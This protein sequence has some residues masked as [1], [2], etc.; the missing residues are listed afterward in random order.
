MTDT[1]KTDVLVIGA[2][3]AGIGVAA[4]LASTHRVTVIEREDQPG[5][6]STGRSA[7][8][9]LPNY[10]N[11]VIRGLNKVSAPLFE[12]RDTSLFPQPL[13]TPRGC[14][15]VADAASIADL[16]NFARTSVG[17]EIISVD[18]AVEMV[19]ILNA[20]HIAAACYQADAWDI[21]VNAL[22]QGWLRKA[23]SLG[24]EIHTRS[25]VTGAERIGDEWH[26]QAGGKT[27]VAQTIVNASGAWADLTA[28]LFGARPLGLTPLRRSIAVLPAPE[29]HDTRGW[30]LVDDVNEAWYMKPDGGRM[31][32][33][34]CD[35]TP[36]D[37]HDAFAD[38][39]V[40]AEGLY[41][42]EQAVTVPVTRVEHSWAGLRTFAPDRT[43]VAGFDADVEGFFWLA[44]QGGY[45][46]QTSPALSAL[47]AALIRGDA[48][49]AELE[50]LLPKLSPARFS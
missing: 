18:R 40:L 15:T 3:I 17:V 38:D 6:H 30:P 46:I 21:D 16:E 43:P 11:D 13:L 49:E 48:P 4:A 44:G 9:F 28:A 22:H 31:F 14:L 29:N 37:P 5:Y 26:V 45:G 19:P 27:F 8:I 7:A 12:N 2:G 36:V 20:D 35:E 33:S 24:V 41:R 39:M 47:A 34:P 25:E 1:I 32:V 23:A 50:P 10:G 42:F